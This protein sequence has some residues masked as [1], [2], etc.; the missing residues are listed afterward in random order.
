LRNR[1]DTPQL[2]VGFIKGGKPIGLL[3]DSIGTAGKEGEAD[4]FRSLR[5]FLE[6]FLVR[7]IWTALES[8]KLLVSLLHARLAAGE[9][10]RHDLGIKLGESLLHVGIAFGEAAG[11]PTRT[12]DVATEVGVAVAEFVGEVT[13]AR[14]SMRMFSI[15]AISA[16]GIQ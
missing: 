1:A 14:S 16:M 3:H 9:L 5:L 11:F 10:L 4:G 7:E 2:F 15:A 8:E 13:T 6:P 12:I